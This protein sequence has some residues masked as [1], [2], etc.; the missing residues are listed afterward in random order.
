MRP[1][2][3]SLSGQITTSRPFIMDQSVSLKQ[4][5]P[6]LNVVALYPRLMSRSQS[7]SPS[8]T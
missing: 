6:P 7:F 8:V 4:S 2:V 1:P 3:S 5:P